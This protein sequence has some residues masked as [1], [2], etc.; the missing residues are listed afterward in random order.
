MGYYTSYVMSVSV[1]T[2][3]EDRV[4]ISTH[5]PDDIRSA[6]I[7]EIDKMNVFE[8][9]D[10]DSTCDAY[11]K[12]YNHASDMTLLSIRFPNLLFLLH[13]EGENHDDVWNKYY[14][15]GKEQ[16]CPAKITYDPFDFKS[17]EPSLTCGESYTYQDS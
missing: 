9:V 2:V 7:E 16:I 8:D 11:D 12:W 14:L 13:G 4:T 10:V 17:M 15:N 3:N 5:I 1:C 6:L